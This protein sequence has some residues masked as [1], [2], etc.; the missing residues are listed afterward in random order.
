[1]T[2]CH[3]I[4]A[5]EGMAEFPLRHR[6]GIRDIGG[7]VVPKV[8]DI[9][10]NHWQGAVLKVGL[11]LAIHH[12]CHGVALERVVFFHNAAEMAELGHGAEQR[13]ILEHVSQQRREIA[14]VVDRPLRLSVDIL[15]R[16]DAAVEKRQHAGIEQDAQLIFFGQGQDMAGVFTGADIDKPEGIAMMLPQGLH[17]LLHKRPQV[18]AGIFGVW[19]RPL[20]RPEYA[21]GEK[22]LQ[23]IRQ[24]WRRGCGC[25]SRC[26]SR[27][28]AGELEGEV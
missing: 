28:F 11:S 21:S 14:N 1:M 10:A 15:P 9:A 17:G 20:P 16:T 6:G 19:T 5:L 13:F 27:H 12:H 26:L 24:R 25:I 3:D 4:H 18:H 23:A 2:G 22:V 7:A 8:I